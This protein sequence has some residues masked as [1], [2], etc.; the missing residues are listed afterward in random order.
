M[1]HGV[2]INADDFGFSASTN[3]AIN[4]LFA[5]DRISSTTVMP[6]MPDAVGIR[7]TR[8]QF[9]SL[10]V[11]VHLNLTQGR[12][13]CDSASVQSLVREDGR[14]CPYGEFA[15]RIRHRR[16][17][18][19]HVENEL[20]AQFNLLSRWIGSISHFDSHQGIHRWPLVATIAMR[21]AKKYGVK[22]MRNHRHYFI[23]SNAVTRLQRPSLT[24]IG[25]YGFKRVVKETYFNWVAWRGRQFG[26]PKGL[27]AGD[28]QPT[29]AVLKMVTDLAGIDG[30]FEIPCHPA[31]RIDDLKDTTLLQER[32]DEFHL[33]DGS[34]FGRAMEQANWTLV[35]FPQG[36]SA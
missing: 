36:I 13:L 29:L 20:E 31:T 21:V 27:I 11:G 3:E 18:P 33:L 5:K 1:D 12:P 22:G 34:D 23:L 26:Q 7:D 17:D 2:V 9:P 15:R 32:V 30:V 4:H 8:R 35:P 19:N 28:N 10:S 24:N 14:F 25:R 16:I 6:N